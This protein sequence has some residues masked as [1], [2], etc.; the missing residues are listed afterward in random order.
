MNQGW[1][2][3]KREG[4]RGARGKAGIPRGTREKREGTRETRGKERDEGGPQEKERRETRGK[5]GKQGGP[6]GK[7]RGTKGITTEKRTRVGTRRKRGVTRGTMAGIFLE[8]CPWIRASRS[9][10]FRL[11]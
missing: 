1:A 7:R 6:E 8:G 11:L 5:G 10:T 9:K 3:G 4:T 2:R